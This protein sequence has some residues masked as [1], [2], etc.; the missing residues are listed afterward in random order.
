MDLDPEMCLE[1]IEAKVVSGE[2]MGRK[3][4][5]VSVGEGS[6]CEVKLDDGVVTVQ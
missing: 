3:G 5:I 2:H 4:V 1:R 6:D